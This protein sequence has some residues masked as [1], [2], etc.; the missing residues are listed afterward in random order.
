MNVYRFTDR[1]ADAIEAGERSLALAREQ[2]LVEQMGYTLND[3]FYSYQSEGQ[4]E[5]AHVVNLEAR[6]IWRELDNRA[7]LA[8]NLSSAVVYDVISGDHDAAIAHS[9][10]ALA[11]TRAIGNIWGISFS[12]MAVSVVY[13]TRGDFAEAIT[14]MR[15]TIDYGERAGFLI[16]PLWAR[17][18]LAMVYGWLGQIE[19][20]LAEVAQGR[21]HI[22]SMS[23]STPAMAFLLSY[24]IQAYLA[25]GELEQARSFLGSI[26]PD[27]RKVG[28]SELLLGWARAS[29]LLA[30][31]DYEAAR[32]GAEHVLDVMRTVNNTM[33]TSES[34][35]GGPR[36]PAHRP[37]R[38]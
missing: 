15:L 1:S 21:A 11:I 20:C 28:V 14:S 4:M 22:P 23:A 38:G 9:S 3:L 36:H 26:S 31:R 2:G 25:A 34:G 17:A 6:D 33:L 35:R 7:M 29:V 37:R 5:L 8:D 30:A 16:G 32:Q 13:W 18:Q 10:E 24:T 19:R 12:Q 27:T